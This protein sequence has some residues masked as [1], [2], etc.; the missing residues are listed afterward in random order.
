MT[1]E[2]ERLQQEGM[3]QEE[4]KEETRLQEDEV[5]KPEEE[6]ERGTMEEKKQWQ[7]SEEE[8][9]HQHEESHDQ[10]IQKGQLRGDTEE[11]LQVNLR[12]CLSG[13]FLTCENSQSA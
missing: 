11:I 7:E 10:V 8:L 13:C 2:Q 6:E 5:K 12:Y 1:H 4:E 3:A 9:C